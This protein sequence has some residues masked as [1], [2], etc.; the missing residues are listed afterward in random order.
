MDEFPV[1]SFVTYKE[2]LDAIDVLVVPHWGTSGKDVGLGSK[3]L[4]TRP[5]R[6]IPVNGAPE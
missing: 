3:N 5:G 2:Q 1:M 4:Y 6:F